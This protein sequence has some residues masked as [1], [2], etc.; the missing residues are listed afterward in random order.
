MVE[1]IKSIE[2]FLV[3]CEPLTELNDLLGKLGREENILLLPQF[4]QELEQYL[5]KHDIIQ[6]N[7]VQQEQA[8]SEVLQQNLT[9]DTTEECLAISTTEGTPNLQANSAQPLTSNS[10]R[11][12]YYEA[13][14]SSLESASSTTDQPTRDWYLNEAFKYCRRSANAENNPN[15]MYQMVLYC[16][17]EVGQVNQSIYYLERA[18]QYGHA[19]AQYEMAKLCEHGLNLVQVNQGEAIKWYTLAATNGHINAMYELGVY[20]RVE[21]NM[22]DSFSWFLKAAEGG[23]VVAMDAIGYNYYKGIDGVKKN[24]QEAFKWM[25]KAYAKGGITAKFNLAIMYLKGYG[26]EKDDKKAQQLFK[27]H[28]MLGKDLG[29]MYFVNLW[30]CDYKKIG[31][32]KI[33]HHVEGSNDSA[34]ANEDDMALAIQWCKELAQNNPGYA[35]FLVTGDV[36]P[37]SA[38][39]LN[40][41]DKLTLILRA[42]RLGSAEADSLLGTMYT[43][44]TG[45]VKKPDLELAAMYYKKAADNGYVGAI[46]EYG[47]CLYQGSGVERD[48]DKGIRYLE[49]AVKLGSFTAMVDLG[50]IYNTKAF[51]SGKISNTEKQKLISRS[52]NLLVKAVEKGEEFYNLSKQVSN[53]LITTIKHNNEELMVFNTRYSW[54]DCMMYA[55]ALHNLGIYYDSGLGTPVNKNKAIK[56]VKKAAAIGRLESNIE[57]AKIYI[58]KQNFNK[59]FNYLQQINLDRARDTKNKNELKKISSQLYYKLSEKYRDNV[60]PDVDKAVECMVEATKLGHGEATIKVLEWQLALTSDYSGVVAMAMD[61]FIELLHTSIIN[62]QDQADL[63]DVKRTKLNIKLSE[64]GKYFI[65]AI[66]IASVGEAKEDAKKNYSDFLKFDPTRHAA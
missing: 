63:E 66:K 4:P 14:L 62:Q 49:S 29:K 35:M 11:A 54:E 56:C 46:K 52:F 5:I 31:S 42:S 15:A 16:L 43:F 17:N 34:G 53:N 18:A 57:L 32:T 28:G 22:Q 27:E 36:L 33:A 45:G 21:K 19:E 2:N 24:M 26:V 41:D 1:L 20:Y 51:A 61:K 9:L 7:I 30:L 37:Q 8:R 44:G 60:P 47:L 3:D 58:E 13:Y 25:E 59:S 64:Y 55:C 23:H 6:N 38:L 65:E 39:N 40:E 50:A 10:S 12:D 48:E